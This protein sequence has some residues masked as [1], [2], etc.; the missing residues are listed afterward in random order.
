MAHLRIQLRRVRN[1]Q[2]LFSRISFCVFAFWSCIS[3]SMFLLYRH[4]E[5][6]VVETLIIMTHMDFNIQHSIEYTQFWESESECISDACVALI[7]EAWKRILSSWMPS[8]TIRIPTIVVAELSVD[9]QVF[10]YPWLK[11]LWQTGWAWEKMD[12]IPVG[13]CNFRWTR[14]NLVELLR[15]GR[16]LSWSWNGLPMS[17]WT[18]ALW[19]STSEAVAEILFKSILLWSMTLF[20]QTCLWRWALFCTFNG[21]DQMPTIT[22]MQGTVV[23]VQIDPTWSRSSHE[24]RQFPC[25]WRS[26]RYCSMPRPTR[27]IRRARPWWTDLHIWIRTRLSLVTQTPTTRIPRPIASSW[28]VPQPTLMVASLRWKW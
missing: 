27:T 8:S 21:Q 6:H 24:L 26:R 2:A 23:L 25:L 28:M 12:L 22:T 16:T 9:D 15:I 13:C 5:I 19:T 20:H 10:H 1:C 18:G 11:T 17:P 4:L 14:I 7:R 3:F